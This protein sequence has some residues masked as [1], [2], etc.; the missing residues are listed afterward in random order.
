MTP[1]DKTIQMGIIIAA[2]S[3]AFCFCGEAET[4][5]GSGLTRSLLASC[6]GFTLRNWACSTISTGRPAFSKNFSVDIRKRRGRLRR[7]KKKKGVSDRESDLTVSGCGYSAS[8]SAR[9]SD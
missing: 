6:S 8:A 2:E 5:E 4:G 7:R 3:F 9:V 1:E